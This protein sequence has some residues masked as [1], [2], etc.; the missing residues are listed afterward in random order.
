MTTLTATAEAVSTSSVDSLLAE[1]ELGSGKVL[2]K[3]D[4]PT[5]PVINQPLEEN[6]NYHALKAVPDVIS[7][8]TKLE[9][10][11]YFNLFIN[12]IYQ[13]SGEFF[14]PTYDWEKRVWINEEKVVYQLGAVPSNS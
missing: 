14:V 6:V 3:K 1:L 2:T 13:L 7:R 12:R 4:L 5:L 11:Y 8:L 9:S 10:G